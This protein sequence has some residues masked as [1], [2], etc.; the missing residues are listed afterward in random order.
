MAA[1]T[2]VEV[3]GSNASLSEAIA[4][5]SVPAPDLMGFNAWQ[6]WRKTSG[7][8]PSTRK[9]DARAT[10]SREEAGLWRSTMLELFGLDWEEQLATKEALEEDSEEED[11][12]PPVNTAAAAA[13]VGGAAAAE[14]R[15]PLGPQAS[16]PAGF[17]LFGTARDLGPAGARSPGAGSNGSARS[18]GPQTRRLWDELTTL[19]KEAVKNGRNGLWAWSHS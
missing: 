18:D 6:V 2:K 14:P 11:G 19:P 17:D 5:G 7:T 16:T 10:T 3:S 12:Q 1:S 13:A 9:G 8:R 15:G 4:S